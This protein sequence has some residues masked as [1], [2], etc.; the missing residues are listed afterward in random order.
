MK[1][2]SILFLLLGMSLTAGKVA[3]QQVSNTGT[4][5][6]S[7]VVKG[8][9]LVADPVGEDNHKGFINVAYEISGAPIT[10]NLHLEINTKIPAGFT[11]DVTNAN[12][13]KQ[14]DWATR[15]P[16]THVATDINVSGLAAGSYKLNIYRNGDRSTKQEVPF[17]KE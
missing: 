10:S 8:H 4:A 1:K 13:S 14:A 15:Q 9:Y 17:T 11:A 3:G 12:G 5:A 7:P 2:K 6:N 16:A